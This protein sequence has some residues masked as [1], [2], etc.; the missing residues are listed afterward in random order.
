MGR[1]LG[2]GPPIYR[3]L[4]FCFDHHGSYRASKE[5]RF[6]LGLLTVPN[7]NVHASDKEHSRENPPNG[8]LDT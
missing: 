8:L 5:L 2:G 3:L 1:H 6:Q 4:R 7:N